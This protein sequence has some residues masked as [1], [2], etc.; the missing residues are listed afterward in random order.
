M[1]WLKQVLAS[2][3]LLPFPQNKK[4]YDFNPTLHGGA[5]DA[6]PIRLSIVATDRARQ[7]G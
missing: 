6:P 7:G 5:R 1:T 4:S 3:P 2:T